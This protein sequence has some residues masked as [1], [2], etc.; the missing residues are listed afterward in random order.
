M[1]QCKTL[2]ED[3]VVSCSCD[4]DCGNSGQS[5]GGI[6]RDVRIQNTI[7]AR[8]TQSFSA[9]CVGRIWVS[10]R[11]S[12]YHA[13]VQSLQCNR[14]PKIRLSS[15]NSLKKKKR[16]FTRLSL[17][18]CSKSACHASAKA[19]TMHKSSCCFVGNQAI[20]YNTSRFQESI[21]INRMT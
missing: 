17:S 18:A 14:P 16:N 20:S 1:K 10:G 9:H 3:E 2:C 8:A 15:L 19:Q 12:Y 21:S 11:K 4:C 7:L 13:R 6:S 5:R